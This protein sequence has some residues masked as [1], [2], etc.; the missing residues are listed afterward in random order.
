MALVDM[1]TNFRELAQATPARDVI[2][3]V[4]EN[5]R[6]VQGIGKRFVEMQD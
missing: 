4:N 3:W 2:V 1:M 5:F 6:Q